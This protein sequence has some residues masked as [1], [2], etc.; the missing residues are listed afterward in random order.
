MFNFSK[1]RIL[2]KRFQALRGNFPFKGRE[3]ALIIMA[4]K[5]FKG[6][7]FAMFLSEKQDRLS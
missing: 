3:K 4:E 1:F 2:R 5:F 6:F 7:G